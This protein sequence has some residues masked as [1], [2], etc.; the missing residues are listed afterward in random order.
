MAKNGNGEGGITRHKKSGLYMARYTVQTTAGS[1]RKTLYGKTRSEVAAKLSRALADR[2]GG[3]TYDA[4]K[5]TVGE[6]LARW[7]SNS[8][9]DTVRQRTYERYESIVRVHLAPAIG[10]VKLK[11]LTPDHVRGLYREKLDG[12]LAPR[13]VLHIHRTLSK[14]LKQA[15]DDGL[16]PRNAAALV[17]PPRPRREEI[18]PLNRE[19]VQALFEAARGDRLEALYV[20]A[21]TAGLRR[22]ELQG[23]KWEDLNL[24]AGTLQVRRTLSEPKG[25]YI[26][27]APKSGKG[28]N[29]RLTQRATLALRDHRKRQLEER[30]RLGTL[31]Q[32]HDLVF[33]SGAGTPVSGGN[34][35]RA[36]KAHLERAELA[37]TTRL[38]DLRHT[39]ATLLLRQGVNPKFVQ[40]LLGHG[41]VSLTLNV[42]SHILPDMGDIAASA[43]DDALG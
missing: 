28:R 20:V 8:V 35:N 4:G 17:K 37:S 19:Q 42:Y 7:L 34:L 13:T 26:F 15:T 31:W 9:R 14:A 11:A 25:G 12:G 6:Y 1:K 22:G 29:I 39:C 33:P 30:M 40:E 24:E 23:L 5:Q 32:D 3:L 2:E 36:F 38:H 10:K 41:D 27:E 18:R 16:I 43:M 21:V